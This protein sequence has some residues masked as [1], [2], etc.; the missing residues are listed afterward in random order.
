MLSAPRFFGAAHGT[1]LM[2]ALLAGKTVHARMFFPL[3][4]LFRNV[5]FADKA[6]DRLPCHSQPPLIYVI[7]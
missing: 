6:R 3:N 2:A 1:T 4:I 5:N 7:Q